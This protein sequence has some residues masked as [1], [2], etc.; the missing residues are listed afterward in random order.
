M[1]GV[2]N[3]DPYPYHMINVKRRISCPNSRAFR[4]WHGA[5]RMPSRVTS[6]MCKTGCRASRRSSP[7]SM[8]SPRSWA[9]DRWLPGETRAMVGT[10]Q[11]FKV[12]WCRWRTFRPRVPHLQR[13]WQMDQWSRGDTL[14]MVVTVLQSKINS[15]ATQQPPPAVSITCG[16][17]LHKILWLWSW[18]CPFMFMHEASWSSILLPEV[19]DFLD[20]QFSKTLGL[21]RHLRTYRYPKKITLILV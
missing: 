4:L 21:R 8:L 16:I 17:C 1:I 2:L 6:V 5:L 14:S 18:I 19:P 11:Q 20:I 3:F 12:D 13:F 15:E 7:L 9:M 10:A